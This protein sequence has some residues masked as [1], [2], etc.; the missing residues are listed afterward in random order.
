MQLL[1]PLERRLNM[2][3]NTEKT[4]H[5]KQTLI[6]VVG[7]ALSA[8]GYVLED[9]PIQQQRGLIRFQKPLPRLGHDIVG[10]I[11]WQLLAFEQSPVAQFQVSLLRNRGHDARAKTNYD[12]RD[13]KTLS[14]IMWHVFNAQ[15]MPSDD[16]WWDFK[17]SHEL[18][19]AL[20][21][22]GRTV[23]GYG[24]PWLE[25]QDSGSL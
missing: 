7:Q 17:T 15:L 25:M 8:A 14:W 19:H 20:A 16:A 5:F 24:I 4:Q 1:N 13:E 23:F 9:S 12:H 3:Y 21:A 10:F 2:F 6:T 11:E 22:A 18:G